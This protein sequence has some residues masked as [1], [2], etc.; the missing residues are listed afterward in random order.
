MIP[1][2]SPV[3]RHYP[4][5]VDNNCVL[6]NFPISIKTQHPCILQCTFEIAALHLFKW[7]VF[8]FWKN[9]QCSDIIEIIRVVVS[10]TVLLLNKYN[11]KVWSA[12][13]QI[14]ASTTICRIRYSKMQSLLNFGVKEVRY[15]K[16]RSN[17][18]VLC[19]ILGHSREGPEAPSRM[20]VPVGS[21]HLL[22][23]Y[24]QIQM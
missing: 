20:P 2:I 11:P 13:I 17:V 9:N 15:S 16:F 5:R 14:L 22:Q 12:I 19:P 1:P 6:A 18:A 7:S 8:Y 3:T 23:V 24:L 10:R 4:D 21:H